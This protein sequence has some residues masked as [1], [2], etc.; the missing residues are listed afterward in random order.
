MKSKFFLNFLLAGMIFSF[1]CAPAMITESIVDT[2]RDHYITGL[3]KL[4]KDDMAGAEA[5]FLRAATLQTRSPYGYTGMAYLEIK[6]KNYKNALK[7]ADKAIELD[8]T[9]AE[10]IAAK[11]YAICMLKKDEDWKTEA[12]SLFKKA[13]KY[14]PENQR[15]QFVAGEC[16]LGIQEYEVSLEYFK[17]AAALKGYFDAKAKSRVGVVEKLVPNKPKSKKGSRIAI[18]EKIDRSDLCV[19]LIYELNLKVLIGEMR[20][21]IFD[22]IYKK[23]SK[24]SKDSLENDKQ[25]KIPPDISGSGEKWIICEIIPLFLDDLKIFPNGYFYPDKIVTK[26]QFAHV[27]QSIIVMLKN[28]QSFAT[29][30]IGSDSPFRDVNSDYYSYNSILLAT[31]EELMPWDKVSGNFYPEKSVSGMEAIEF[32]GKLSIFLKNK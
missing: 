31:G 32:L 20:P 26:A 22:R 1:S 28:D 13:A 2:P 23:D 8:K 7:M 29:R 27:M 10:A 5:E 3:D 25:F 11:G 18:R 30:Y 24:D 4:E 14:E 21:D 17:K 6:R 9:F 15:V 16:C 12:L 19:L